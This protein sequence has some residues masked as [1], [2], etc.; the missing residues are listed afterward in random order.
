MEEYFEDITAKLV[1][2]FYQTSI[3]LWVPIYV[4]E[5]YEISS[6]GNVRYRLP[7]GVYRYPQIQF[8]NG[9]RTVLL[10]INIFSEDFPDF[11]KNVNPVLSNIKNK[12]YN[13]KV[14]VYVVNIAKLYDYY[15]IRRIE[16]INNIC[17]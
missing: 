14:A 6:F 15:F 16:N 9:L 8:T 1:E 2:D 17:Y 13:P 10:P 3:E 5:N 11:E 7:R 12:F 4:T